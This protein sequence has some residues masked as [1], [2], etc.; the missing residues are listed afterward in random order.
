M[1]Y[2]ISNKSIEVPEEG[3]FINP[4]QGKIE[5]QSYY[6]TKS[7]GKNLSLGFDLET[8][9]LDAY[10]NDILLVIIGDKHNQYVIDYTSVDN[11]LDYLPE[12]IDEWNWIMQNGKFDQKFMIVKN[13]YHIT[14]M[15]DIMIAAQKRY[16]GNSWNPK[17]NPLGKRYDLVSIIKDVLKIDPMMDKSTREDFIGI[18]P[19]NFNPEWR[20]IDYAAKDIQYLEDV[21]DTLEIMLTKVGITYM[22]QIGLYICYST[23]MLELT[24]FRMNKEQWRDNVK[25]QKEL[26]F[27]YE[28]KLDEEFRQVRDALNKTDFLFTGKYSRNRNQ[29][30]EPIQVN[31]FDEQISYEKYL[32][33]ANKTG[34]SKPGKLA[35]IK[36]SAAYV[37]WTST[38]EIQKIFAILKLLMPTDK[39][40]IT[41][42][43]PTYAMEKT[44]TKGKNGKSRIKMVLHKDYKFT[45][46]AGNIRE[47]INNV[48]NHPARLFLETLIKYRECET[49]INTF[50]ENILEKI[51]PVTG[52]LHSTFRTDKA[53]NGRFQSGE[54]DRTETLPNGTKIRIKSMYPNF[55]NIPRAAVYRTA[56]LPINE[57]DKLVTADL[58]GAEVTIMCDK[59]H[60][61]QLYEWA[62]KNDDA[63]SPIATACWRNI[64]LYRAAV[65]AGFIKNK[66]GFYKES[67]NLEH[68]IEQW[69][70]DNGDGLIGEGVAMNYKLY[71]NFLITKEL[72]KEFRQTFKNVTFAAVYNV[73]EKKCAKMLNISQDEAGVVLWTIKQNIPATFRYVES[74]ADIA[75]NTGAVTINDRTGE[76]CIFPDVSRLLKEGRDLE[77]LPFLKRVEIEGAARNITISGT[78]SAMIKEAFVELTLY[79]KEWGTGAYMPNKIHDEIVTGCKAS[80]TENANF[81][82][83]SDNAKRIIMPNQQ[84]F[85]PVN[86]KL[87]YSYELVEKDDIKYVTIQDF[88][89][90]T[91][92]EAANRYLTHYKMG[93]AVE[94]ADTWIK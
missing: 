66:Y 36:K 29:T 94:V 17:D 81:V 28:C 70:F 79:H 84:L 34:K 87:D 42:A 27:K 61:N 24:G 3:I 33:T 72:N 32:Q 6:D 21:K 7:L 1:I 46:K 56:F 75:L 57:G 11:I 18:Q 60:D 19:E 45:T 58:S 93:C 8:N 2:Y 47:L 31:L 88:I 55:Q 63:H 22:Q 9:G 80:A 26:K 15:Y 39:N 76:R 12:N 67:Y 68:W 25:R 43:I 13:D 71:H 78:Q 92:M 62:V 40:K 91:M 89:K 50:G 5:I 83:F 14:K 51:N 16:Q 4:V 30:E 38:V 77:E 59:A 48:P 49:A 53:N 85:L 82:W 69:L 10:I 74:I 64:F 23:A 65:E 44:H 90:L 86:R 73:G 41:E 52:R 20:H 35:T 37:N 54:R